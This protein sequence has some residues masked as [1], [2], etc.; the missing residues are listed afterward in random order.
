MGVTGDRVGVR[1]GGIRNGQEAVIG[2]GESDIDADGLAAQAGR[3]DAGVL[4]CLPGQLQRHPLL[5]VDVVGFGFGHREELR[6]EA[7]DVLQVAATGAGLC[8]SR[9]QPRLFQEFRPAPRGQISNGVA[10]FQQ[11]LPGFFGAVHVPGQSRGQANDRDVDAF[12][13][14]GTRPVEGVAAV[15]RSFRLALDDA[16]RQR[17]D[18][19]MLESH[20][21]RER[22][23]GHVLDVG[24]HRH[25]I[26]RRQAQLHHGHRLVDRVGRLPHG[27]AHPVAQPFPHLGDRQL[28]LL[29]GH[30]RLVG[31]GKIVL[32]HGYRTQFDSLAKAVGEPTPL[33]RLPSR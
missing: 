9:G 29:G 31:F 32:C 10:A 24:G 6:I 27:L 13:R 23:A 30:A 5:R 14:A 12:G 15:V 7:L 3:R 16:G 20:R 1:E 18:G 33:R 2:V 28:G 22:D 19:R 21:D 17:F 8:N 25:G 26:P 4:Q 11:R